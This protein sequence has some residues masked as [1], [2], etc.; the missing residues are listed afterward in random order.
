MLVYVHQFLLN[1][2]FTLLV[3]TV[4]FIVLV[5]WYFRISKVDVPLTQL[6]LGGIF[7]STITIPFVWFV[8]PILLYY[9]TVS[10]IA[11]GE[12]FAFVIEAIFYIF[13]FKFSLRQAV[14]ISFVANASSFLLGLIL[15]MFL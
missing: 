11:A 15:H 9:S 3:E 13:A 2:S 6:I 10:A 1:W 8:F 7:A 14:I 4:V 12:I 5:R